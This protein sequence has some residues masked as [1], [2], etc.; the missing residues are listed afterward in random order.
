MGTFV[1]FVMFSA[2]NCLTGSLPELPWTQVALLY[3]KR[4]L[5]RI[6]VSLLEKPRISGGF[7]PQNHEFI[8]KKYLETNIYGCFLKWWYPQNTP[9]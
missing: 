4:P 1:S 2:K 5:Q 7:L 9:K 3:G 8:E 6:A